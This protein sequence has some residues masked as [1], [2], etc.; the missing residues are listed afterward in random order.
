[1]TL[2]YHD[3]ITEDVLEDNISTIELKPYQTVWLSN[4]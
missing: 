4:K 1:M 2:K 3:L